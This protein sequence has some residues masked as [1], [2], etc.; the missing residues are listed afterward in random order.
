MSPKSRL[1]WLG[2]VIVGV[3]VAV[4][5][6]GAWYVL[7]ARPQPGDVVDTIAVEGEKI[8]IRD[9]VG[10]ERSFVELWRGDAL[11]WQALVPHYGGRPGAPGIAVGKSAVS[12]RIVREGRAEIFAIARDTAE[13]LGGMGLGHGHGMID[14][15][16]TGPVTLTD[17]AR[18]YE[19]VSGPDWH[20]LVGIELVTGRPLWS[21][22]L[23]VAPVTDGGV[24]GERVWVAQ[25][26]DRHAFDVMTGKPL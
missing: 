24:V 11:A 16:A 9:E 19:I 18:S 26:S 15:A 1:G 20:Q 6:V 13:K 4:A 5:A 14:P 3:G 17:H 2:P 7:H 10:G 23:G 22:E 21:V 25:G 8:V 12:I